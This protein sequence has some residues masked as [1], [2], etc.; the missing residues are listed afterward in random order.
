LTPEQRKER[1]DRATALLASETFQAAARD[2]DA[3]YRDA[4]FATGIAAV[5]ER[6]VLF[7]EYAGFRRMVERLRRWKDDGAIVSHEIDA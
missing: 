7:A 1:G 3:F 5:D 6:E 4:V 2:V